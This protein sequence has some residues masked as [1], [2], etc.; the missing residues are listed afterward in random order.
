MLLI[1]CLLAAES[2]FFAIPKKETRVTAAP[3]PTSFLKEK[4]ASGHLK[5]D[6]T[7]LY[8]L[9]GEDGLEFAAKNT[10]QFPLT[11]VIPT[12]IS[13]SLSSVD[14]SWEPAFKF[15]F[16]YYFANRS[17]ELNARWTWYHSHTSRSLTEDL[18]SAGAGLLPLWIP[19]QAAIATFPVY[20]Q[21]KGTFLLLLNN[22]DLEL[23]YLGGISRFFSL[24]LH[25]G[26]KGIAIH[27]TLRA[28][29]SGGFLSGAD[30]M[31]GSH[32]EASARC[33]GLG[34]RVGFGSRWA[35]PKGLS[36]IAELSGASALSEIVTKRHDRSI[37]RVSAVPQK[38]TIK[39]QEHFWLWRPLLEGKVGLMWEYA[40]SSKSKFLDLEIAYEIQHYWE[41]NMLT[42]YADAAVF[43]AAY[44]NRGNLTLQGLS[45]TLAL[46]Y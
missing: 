31:L 10:P 6:F 44:N 41:Q 12:D 20:S 24:K 42:R 9:A 23:S 15:L 32:A 8:W 22:F 13:A 40:F 17:W 33:V 38:E 2:P 43:Y 35:L 37:G 5:T 39:F 3:E 4:T 27:Q 21:A 29:Y 26:L 45:F 18:S 14:F 19:P 25:G 7:F 36:L 11:A 46:G 28:K 16:G 30:Q 34:P 1:P